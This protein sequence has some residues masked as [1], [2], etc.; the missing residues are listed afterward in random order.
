MR[1]LFTGIYRAAVMLLAVN[2]SLVAASAIDYS[3]SQLQLAA[4]TAQLPL[5][6]AVDSQQALTIASHEAG[7]MT[8]IKPLLAKGQYQQV[9]DAFASRPLAADSAALQQLRGQVLLSVK[10]YDDAIVALL[11]ATK[12]A[13]N[14]ASAQRSLALAY[15]LAGQTQQA[16]QPLQAALAL[17]VQDPALFGQLAYLNLQQYG[18][19]SAIAGYRQALFLE[20]DNSQWQQGLV[21]ALTQAQAYSEANALLQQLLN[22]QPEDGQWWLQ[23]AYLQLQQQHYPD[24]LHALDV[25]MRLANTEQPNSSLAS[26]NNLALL[27]KLHVQYGSVDAGL[28]AFQRALTA[29]P[30][31][32]QLA[33][34]AQQLA[35]WFSQQQ[36][37]PQLQQFLAML[38]GKPVAKQM[39]GLWLAK[40]Q[41]ALANKQTSQ[42][43]QQLIAGL[44]AAPNHGQGLLLLANL[45]RER[46]NTALAVSYYQR[47]SAISSSQE[48]ALLGQAQ[49]EIDRKGYAQALSLLRQVLQLN[50]SRHE[51]RANIKNLE[52]LLRYES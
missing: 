9:A 52:Q 10:R 34:D 6:S 18:P 21:H 42:A 43:E 40:A 1:K 35:D 30:T 37:W 38:E 32:A 27:A 24:A 12:Q 41:M 19:W 26:A 15:L 20:P 44:Q 33:A 22:Q 3:N 49:L 14:L 4:P 5:F 31:A 47:A 25:A 11:A 17:G 28:T 51:L 29:N 50:P 48:A 2:V 46:G 13:P 23:L 16:R 7:F 8:D 39:P 36:Q 45:Y